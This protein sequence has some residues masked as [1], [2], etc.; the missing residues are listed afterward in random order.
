[1]DWDATGR[2][3]VGPL[4]SP[5]GVDARRAALGLPALEVSLAQKRLATEAEQ[6][7]PDDPVRRQAEFEAWARR[8]G[9]RM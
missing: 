5:E 7:A 4:E 3:S 1:V 6:R 8:V 2:L 9:W